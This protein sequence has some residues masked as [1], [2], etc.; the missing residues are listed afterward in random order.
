M[1][2]A[3]KHTNMQLVQ[4]LHCVELARTCPKYVIIYDD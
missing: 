3:N 1:Y 2:D 4:Q